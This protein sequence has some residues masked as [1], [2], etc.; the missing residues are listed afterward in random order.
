MKIAAFVLAILGIGSLT[1]LPRVFH[2][3]NNLRMIA[4]YGC[5]CG[6]LLLTVAI[7]ILTR[8]KLAWLLGFVVI[9][10]SWIQFVLQVAIMHQDASD[11]AIVLIICAVGSLLGI[12]YWSVV[13]YRQKKWFYHDKMA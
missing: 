9:L 11:K 12:I 3:A 13:W 2:S 1:A 10:Q 5:I 7:G 4:V 8:W 6:I